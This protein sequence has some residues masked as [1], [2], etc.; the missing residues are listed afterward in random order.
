MTTLWHDVR[1]GLRTLARDPRFTVAAVLTLTLGI[2]A[3]TAVFSLVHGVLLRPLPYPQPQQLVWLHE[4]LPAMAEKFPVLPVNARH[5]LEWRQTSVSFAG[6]ALLKPGTMNLTGREEPEI[7]HVVA[8]SANLFETLGVQPALGRSFLP[9]EEEEGRHH[10]VVLSDRCWQRTFHADPSILGTTVTLNGEVYT[11]IGVLPPGFRLPSPNPWGAPELTLHEQSD[12]YTPKIFTPQEKKELAGLF[13]FDVL[14][15]LKP[16]VTRARALAELN[17]ITTALVQTVGED[18]KL[19]VII[20]PLREAMVESSRRGLLMLLGAVGAGLLI[21]CL[22]LASLSLVRAERHGF[23]AALRTALGAHRTQLLRQVL[24][25]TGLVAL[26]G[27]ALGVTLATVGLRLLVSVAPGDIPRLNEVRIDGPVLLF[28]LAVTVATMLLLGLLP[29]WR[30]AQS[31]PENVLRAAGR[32]VATAAGL[33]IRSALISIEVG[34]GVVLLILAGLLLNSFARILRAD[35]GFHAPTVLAVEVKPSPTKYGAWEQRRQFH[36]RLLEEVTS[37]PGVRSAAL[38][39]ALPLTGQDWISEVWLAGDSRQGMERPMANVR[40]ISAD[41][42]GTMGIPLVEGRTFAEADRTRAVA[43]ISQRL[44]RVLW[45]GDDWVVGRRFLHGSGKEYEVIGVAANVRSFADR[46]TVPMLYRPYWDEAPEYTFVVARSFGD[47]FSISATV[48]AAVRNVD[49][50]L[51]IAAMRTMQEVLD[52]SVSQRRFQMLIASLFAACAL[53][54]AALGI[55]GVV[56]YSVARQTRDIGIRA[57]LGTRPVDLCGMVLLRGMGPV[58]LGL[59]AGL[60][61][62]LVLGRLLGSLL[63]EI[64]PYDPLTLAVVGVVVSA[65]AAAAC[66]FPAR[67]AAKIDPMV[68]LRYE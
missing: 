4:F 5:F 48:R 42:F 19:R 33:R 2:G 16:G 26:L 44:A 34:L 17:G 60:A 40:F 38:V 45:P 43:V 6:L 67:R 37:A 52:S 56:S 63:Y 30:M 15:R 18:L 29:A 14:G 49:A 27:A 55:Y 65:V 21:A 31:R 24:T 23:D 10:V 3:T 54:L 59:L 20:K 22:N 57:A 28:T 61:G 62:A 9:E 64:S 36:A 35:K 7:L 41:Y 8:A 47:P 13:N 11:I 12:L 39:S 58:G 25:E 68:A 53:L 66:Y 51:P 50:D 1:Y 46:E 32:T